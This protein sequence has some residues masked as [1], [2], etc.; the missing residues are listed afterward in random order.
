MV[1]W[2][3]WLAWL[4]IDWGGRDEE[5]Y[6]GPVLLLRCGGIFFRRTSFSR[7]EFEPLPDKK[8]LISTFLSQLE[9]FVHL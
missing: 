9:G 1:F 6:D 8:K 7:D 2:L 3:L 5:R 4:L